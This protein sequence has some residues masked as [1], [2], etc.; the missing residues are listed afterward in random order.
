[1]DMIIASVSLVACIWSYATDLRGRHYDLNDIVGRD[2]IAMV[3]HYEPA[4]YWE[5]QRQRL[6]KD[7]TA[8]SDYR[9]RNDYGVTLM[10][11]RQPKE[12]IT[13]LQAIEK[14]HPGKYETAVNLGTAYELAGDDVRALQWIRE[15]M[16]RNPKAH[17]GTEWVHVRIL[18]AKIAIARDPHWL[19]T[20]TVLGVD[21]GASAAPRTLPRFP[22]NNI[23][24][25]MALKGFAESIEYQLSERLEF[26]HAPDPVVADLLFDCANGFMVH[27][28]IE[29]AEAY[30]N[31][32]LKYGTL[33]AQLARQRINYIRGILAK[34][35]K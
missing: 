33:R 1:M 20:H 14:E 3:Q 4:G 29:T 8:T 27:G 30:F 5:T 31:E 34:A 19:D 10:H 17:D 16:R 21:F 35:K 2:R 6:G 18:E 7:L 25:P 28:P 24:Q 9:T 13:F 32:S 11:L 15:G 26:V 12:A 22:P 23:G